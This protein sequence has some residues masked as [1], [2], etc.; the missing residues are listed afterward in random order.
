[1]RWRSNRMCC[2]F[3]NLFGWFFADRIQNACTSLGQGQA[4]DKNKNHAIR[5]IRCSFN[6]SSIFFS[7]N[8]YAVHQMS[9]QCSSVVHLFDFNRN[10]IRLFLSINSSFVRNGVFHYCWH[11]RQ[12]DIKIGN[13]TKLHVLHGKVSTRLELNYFVLRIVTKKIYGKMLWTRVRHH[14]S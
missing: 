3:A 14:N 6:P 2:C 4:V 8:P 1:M 9:M 5:C 13:K 11:N 10:K 12:Q 7:P